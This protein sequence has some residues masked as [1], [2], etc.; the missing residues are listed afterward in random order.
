MKNFTHLREFIRHV[1][2]EKDKKKEVL[3]EPDEAPGKEEE[4]VSAGGVAGVSTPL[5]T[6]PNFPKR[7]N[8]S[9]SPIKIAQKA[10][11]NAKLA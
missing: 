4:E 9:Q 5:G 3:G 6:G 7:T 10:F 2:I 11:A 8:R 1:L